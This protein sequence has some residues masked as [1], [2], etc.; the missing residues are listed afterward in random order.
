MGR[1]KANATF[2][3]SHAIDTIDQLWFAMDLTPLVEDET[4]DIKEFVKAKITRFEESVLDA[5]S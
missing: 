3:N 5:L 4:M 2:S 1:R